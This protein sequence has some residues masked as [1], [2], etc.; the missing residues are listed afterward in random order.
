MGFVK[1]LEVPLIATIAQM[2]HVKMEGGPGVV[3]C[4]FR[5]GCRVKGP[6]F[7]EFTASAFGG[8]GFRG[9]DAYCL[10]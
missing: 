2:H 3:R 6:G 5:S 1:Y 4:L 9:E 10:S 8:F 7:G